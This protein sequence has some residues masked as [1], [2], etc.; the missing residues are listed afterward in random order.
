MKKGSPLS[1]D[2]RCGVAVIPKLDIYMNL[3]YI[4]E[5][6]NHSEHGLGEGVV[7]DLTKNKERF[8]CKEYID[9]FFNSPHLQNKSFK[10]RN[11]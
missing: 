1:G 8:N 4:Q 6:K 10:K 2:S 9:N 7:L 5:K 3:I 11:I